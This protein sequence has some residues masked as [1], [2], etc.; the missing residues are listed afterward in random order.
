MIPMPLAWLGVAAS[1]LLVGVLPLQLAG[2]LHGWITS[3][4][5]IPMLAYEG[6][7]GFWLMI[8][9]VPEQ[10]SRQVRTAVEA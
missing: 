8:K 1:L 3:F 9:G 5:W 7:L 6:P 2:L 10:P 4:V